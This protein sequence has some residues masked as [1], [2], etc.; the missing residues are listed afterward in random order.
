MIGDRSCLKAVLVNW[1]LERFFMRA[2]IAL[3]FL[4]L[5]SAGAAAQS[6]GQLRSQLSS[7]QAGKPNQA[8]IASLNRKAKS[9]GCNRRGGGSKARACASINKQLKHAKTRVVNK[10]RV[11]RIRQQLA[12]HCDPAAKQRQARWFKRSGPRRADK[13][14]RGGNIFSRL[15][16]RQ[17]RREYDVAEDSRSRRSKNV[18]RVSL[19]TKSYAGGTTRFGSLA[20]RSAGYRKGRSR[21]GGA[22]TMCVRLC[23][24]FYFPINNSSHSDNYYD[25]LAM[26]VGRCPGADVSLYVHSKD[27]PVEQMRSTMTGEPYVNLPTAFKYR[28]ALSP[29]CGCANGTRIV[30]DEPNAEGTAVASAAPQGTFK[31]RT[32]PQNA[33]WQPYRA[34]YDGT[35]EALQVSRTTHDGTPLHTTGPAAAKDQ[36][37][38]GEGENGQGTPLPSDL[39]ASAAAVPFDQASSKARPVGPQFFSEAVADFAGSQER[40]RQ[41]ER[42]RRALPANTTSITVEPLAQLPATTAGEDQ[43]ALVDETTPAPADVEQQTSAIVVTN[44]ATG[45]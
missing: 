27:G 19:D 40:R 43:Q 17:D 12:T 31:P 41:V 44:G 25:E 9:Y 10:A 32:K 5:F 39:M 30:K 14:N 2:V 22:R 34:V 13:G 6:C 1:M 42:P 26:C 3:I 23:D 35:G 7:A 20:T 37:R 45:G 36:A 15:F 21:V 29:S 38:L 33:G 11:R 28:K 18:E 16:G 24:G 4:V 8:V